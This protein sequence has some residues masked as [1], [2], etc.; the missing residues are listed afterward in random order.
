MMAKTIID[1]YLEIKQ[2]FD[3]SK[4][5]QFV[6]DQELSLLE[7]LKFLLNIQEET[8]DL[9]GPDPY[10]KQ[11]KKFTLTKSQ[12]KAWES[13]NSWVKS[14][15][16]Y[17]IL[18]GSAG[19]GKT[20]LLKMIN[21]LDARIRITAT[22]NKASKVLREMGLDS[23]TIYSLLGIRM[24]PIEDELKLTLPDQIPFI[25]KNTI[26]VVDEC[27]MINT[28]LLE[29]I[30]K[31]QQ[32]CGIKF[33]FVGDHYQLPP[34]GELNSKVW[35]IVP[36][37]KHIVLT[38]IVRYDNQILTLADTLR[39]SIR[40][41]N[42]EFSVESDFDEKGGVILYD[43][44]KFISDILEKTDFDFFQNI[45]IGAWRN[46]TVDKYNNKIR[47]KLGYLDKEK[48]AVGERILIASPIQDKE[49][50]IIAHID[51]EFIV[52]G[53]TKDIFEIEGETFSVYNLTVDIS[54]GFLRVVT[55]EDQGKLILVLT[56]ISKAARRETN[57][58]NRMILWQKFWKVKQSFHSVRY[59][60]A[61]TIHR[62][63]GST[64]NQ[65]YLDAQDVLANRDKREA[66]RCLYVGSTRPRYFL[67]IT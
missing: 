34:V 60:Y 36:K 41:K 45:K 55:D 38:D 66:W 48:Y 3:D 29:F 44:K 54:M 26:I 1:Q 10:I 58:F 4:I 30:K 2:Y 7:R 25:M 16:P 59:G 12:E 37:N 6:N 52:K 31:T 67:H 20:T 11:T 32:K 21:K 22:T 28:Q 9:L 63:Q 43:R 65:L 15:N 53:V 27:S 61:M 33:L 51:D 62:L 64:V 5:P 39:K 57:K 49:G 56:H 50:A 13:L 46:A 19:T 8:T 35:G 42:Y 17:A 18:R 47:R 40:D 24:S 14:Q 23:C